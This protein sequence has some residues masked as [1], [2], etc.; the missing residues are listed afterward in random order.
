MVLDQFAE[1]CG[2][3]FECDKGFLVGFGVLG[4]ERVILVKPQVF[5]NNSGDVLT[6][7]YAKEKSSNFRLVIVHDDLDLDLGRVKI[8]YGG[9]SG[10]HRGVESIIGQPM[11]NQ[12]TRVRVGIGR[13]AFP[14]TSADYV[15]SPMIDSDRVEFQRATKRAAD[16]VRCLV[17][18][19]LIRAMNSFNSSKIDSSMA[20]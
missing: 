15:L 2:V 4:D 12:F 14:M 18:D 1:E 17:C 20:Q 5:M 11:G 9:G 13:P 16:A 10:G 6:T 7:L 3:L 19:G 8:Q